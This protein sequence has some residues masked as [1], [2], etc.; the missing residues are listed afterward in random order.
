MVKLRNRDYNKENIN[1]ES[2]VND[3]EDRKETENN[4]EDK[5][6]NSIEI[7]EEVINL[8]NIISDNESVEEVDIINNVTWLMIIIN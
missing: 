8:E 3:S 4:L 6:D 7:K 5:K 2:D 1:S